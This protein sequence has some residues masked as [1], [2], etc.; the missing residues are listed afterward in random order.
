M[1]LFKHAL[2]AGAS[3]ALLAAFAVPASAADIQGGGSSLLAP[4]IAQVYCA[5]TGGFT[6]TGAHCSTTAADG[7]HGR[8]Y[9][10]TGQ[11]N[12]VDSGLVAATP[13][14]VN[15][16]DDLISNSGGGQKGV[17][18]ADPT[19]LGTQGG[20]SG[21]N[22]PFASVSL[23]LADA[24]LSNAALV[25]FGSS[26]SNSPYFG[27]GGGAIGD[28]SITL[29]GSDGSGSGLTNPRNTTTA[30]KNFGNLIQFPVTIDPVAIGYNPSGLTG[31]SGALKLSKTTYCGI[32]NALITDW[33]NA[34]ITA[35]NGG[36][37][38]TGGVSKAIRLVGRTNGSG[39][40]SIFTHHLAA[41]CAGVSGNQFTVAN[42][43]A[44]AFKNIP[45]SLQSSYSLDADSPTE[46]TD[47]NGTAGSIGY[48]GADYATP[49]TAVA[50]TVLSALLKDSTGAF[51]QPS[52]ANAITAFG[53]IA[54]P[55]GTARS[56]AAQWVPDTSNPS[57][58]YNIIGTTNLV[59]WTTSG[60]TA[61][62]AALVSAGGGSTPEGLLHWYYNSSSPSTP[63][64]T[65]A[66]ILGAAN[67]GQM[68]SNWAQAITDNFITNNSGLNLNIH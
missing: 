59:T 4:Y 34:A 32:F 65:V 45:T 41:V 44:G 15:I 29:K 49:S 47:I 66:G 55:T 39:T 17:L 19:Q 31:L 68:P 54:P 24:A 16:F 50:T 22:Y 25:A 3:V 48:I 53:S 23:G 28:L 63:N 1:S 36:R 6:G 14:T 7:D 56:D 58:G 62:A 64:P 13:D 37:S 61:K 42:L 30:P 26:D 18:T 20:S 51:N 8:L 60:S 27:V 38:V 43:T 46:V 57:S 2:Q 11:T 21:T 40:T 35:D 52:A 9:S 12:I 33:N 10:S 5:R 67:L